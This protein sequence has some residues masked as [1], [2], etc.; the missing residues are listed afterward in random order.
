MARIM[1]T[2]SAE[3]EEIAREWIGRAH[4]LKPILEAAA[5]RIEQAKSLP[6]D[7]LDAMHDAKMFRMT[8]PRSLGGAELYPA[9]PLTIS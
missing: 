4:S 3:Q 5:S 2:R 7:V 1:G 9:P 6:P 8:V